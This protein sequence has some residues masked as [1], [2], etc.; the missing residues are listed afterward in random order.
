MKLI[1]LTGKEFG[2]LTVLR[3]LGDGMWMTRCKCGTEKPVRGDAL[4]SGNTASCRC[5]HREISSKVNTVHG[6]A[7][8]GRITAEYRIWAA[9]IARCK[10]PST[11]DW[12]L[13]GGRG[14]RVC[15]RWANSFQDFLADM[16]RPEPVPFHRPLPEPKRQ[17]RAWQLPLGNSQATGKQPKNL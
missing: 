14:I 10:Y 7:K 17:L 16:G 5:L 3:Y 12:H 8:H 11:K 15:D 6:E 2:R 13:Y 1:D 4:K 9:M